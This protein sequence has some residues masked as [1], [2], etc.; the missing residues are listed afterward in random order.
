MRL[1]RDQAARLQ[2]SKPLPTGKSGPT[3]HQIIPR[4]RGLKLSNTI[5]WKRT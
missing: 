4:S 3:P 2:F 5:I 1:E